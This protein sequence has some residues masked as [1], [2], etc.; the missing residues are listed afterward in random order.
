MTPPLALEGEE[1]KVALGQGLARWFLGS[2]VTADRCSVHG[3]LLG[4]RGPWPIVMCHVR[5][6]TT[7]AETYSRQV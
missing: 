2:T 5:V 1:L 6:F 3:L 4:R 7:V